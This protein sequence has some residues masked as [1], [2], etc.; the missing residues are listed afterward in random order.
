MWPC[1]GHFLFHPY[2]TKSFLI[3]NIQVSLNK[4]EWLVGALLKMA[5]LDSHVIDFIKKDINTSELLEAVKPSVAILLDINN[6]TIKLKRDCGIS[7][8]QEH[9]GAF[10][11]ICREERNKTQ[12]SDDTDIAYPALQLSC[13]THH[14]RCPRHQ[15]CCHVQQHYRPCHQ[16]SLQNN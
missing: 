8:T 7:H 15:G 10:R 9:R 2:S 5:K 14:L 6:Q 11:T 1:S 13:R 16:R 4:M 3:H 12:E